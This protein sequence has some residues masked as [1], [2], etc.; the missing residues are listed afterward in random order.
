MEVWSK[1]D[2][3]VKTSLKKAESCPNYGKAFYQKE[4]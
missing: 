2:L 3:I 4:E 1:Y